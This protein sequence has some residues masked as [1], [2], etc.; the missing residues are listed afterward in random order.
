MWMN[1]LLG[2]FFFFPG[3]GLNAGTSTNLSSDPLRRCFRYSSIFPSER[4]GC[5]SPSTST[6]PCSGGV[7][8]AV[9]WLLVPK[10][11]D[12]FKYCVN[13]QPRRGLRHGG[14]DEGRQLRPEWSESSPLLLIFINLASMWRIS[15]CHK[16][17][18]CDDS[19][20]SYKPIT[21]AG[22]LLRRTGEPFPQLIR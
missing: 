5:L 15:L 7:K 9:I 12:R 19:V 14:K 3:P 10:V 8:V 13:F 17:S 16:T 2:F 1:L 20:K 18:P 4:P 22:A 6:F 11:S 21:P